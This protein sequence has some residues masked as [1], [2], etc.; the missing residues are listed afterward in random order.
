MIVEAASDETENDSYSGKNEYVNVTIEENHLKRIVKHGLG[1]N[2]LG[3]LPTWMVRYASICLR[4]S[5]FERKKLPQHLRRQIMKRKDQLLENATKHGVNQAAA[6]QAA[7]RAAVEEAISG[8][9][10]ALNQEKHAEKLNE[11]IEVGEDLVGR[12]VKI[13]WHTDQSWREGYVEKYDE[14]TC[15]HVVRYRDGEAEFSY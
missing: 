3:S 6:Q 9:S 12:P 14:E 10:M 8:S 2:S 15:K 4:F 7:A 5:D 13:Y 11:E 1:K